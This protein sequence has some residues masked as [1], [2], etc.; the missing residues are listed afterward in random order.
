MSRFELPLDVADLDGRSFLAPSTRRVPV[1]II[2]V[3]KH[4]PP[5]LI[6]RR[7]RMRRLCFT[8][9]R[10]PQ[11]WGRPDSFL[12]DSANKILLGHAN[13]AMLPLHSKCLERL[14]LR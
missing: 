11:V 7:S 9:I 10:D 12:T 8:H 14:Q 2:E 3:L 1:T 4:D 13:Q 5:D 6:V